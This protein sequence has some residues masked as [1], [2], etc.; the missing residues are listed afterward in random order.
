MNEYRKALKDILISQ[1]PGKR[2]DRQFLKE[3]KTKA[4]TP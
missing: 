4:E 1:K 3:V 2:V